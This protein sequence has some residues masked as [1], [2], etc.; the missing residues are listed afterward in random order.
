MATT[1]LPRPDELVFASAAGSGE[2]KPFP[3]IPRGWGLTFNDPTAGGN[4]GFPPMEWFNSLLARIDAATQYFLQR[5]VGEWAASTLYAA[6]SVVSQ[7]PLIFRA[8]KS[9][10]G[11]QPGSDTTAWAQ[12]ADASAA[13]TL[14]PPGMF[15]LFAAPA[16]PPGWLKM[17]GA[18][19]SRTTYAA[20]FAAIGTTYG[21]SGTTF[22]LPDVRGD[23]PRCWDDGRG[24]DKN[25]V[26]GSWQAADMQPHQHSGTAL[27]VGDHTHG[28]TA[29]TDVNGWH[30]HNAYTDAQ[31]YH[32][33]TGA[34][35]A[36]GSHAHSGTT[37]A[38]GNHQHT[39]P[40]A[41]SVQAGSDNGG[42]NVPVNTGYSSGRYMQPTDYAG[43]HA[44]N[45]YVN[46]GGVHSHG[47]AIDA[48]GSHSH[49][50]GVYGDGNHQHNV[51]ASMGAAGGHQHT[52]TTDWQGGTETR[53]RNVAFLACIK[54]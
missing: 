44:H 11:I 18:T 34:T 50:V 46:A 35:D 40:N 1:L 8:L 37:D 54:Y 7:G 17:N 5:G 24:V 15:G 29:W 32:N 42:A 36:Q 38:Q 19:L 45:L 12:L 48:G 52:I 27:W 13:V 41:G 2:I 4:G 23:F 25:R 51:I 14:A 30:G 33:H 39:L 53:P 10:Q 28:L 3:D 6:G 31:G 22:A 26:F 21:G 49:N 16:V 43:Q 47:L 9:S 20:L